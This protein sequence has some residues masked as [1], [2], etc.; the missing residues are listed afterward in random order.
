MGNDYDEAY[1]KGILEECEAKCLKS[2]PSIKPSHR[3][4]FFEACEKFHEAFEAAKK[5]ETDEEMNKVAKS[6]EKAMKKCVKS[7]NKIFEKLDLTEHPKIQT[8][9]LKGRIIVDAKPTGLADF[10]S[11]NKKNG[12][13]VDH[14]FRESSLMKRMLLNG[15]AKDGNYGAA[16]KIYTDILCTFPDEEDDF[17]EINRK[18]ALAVALELATPINEFDTKVPVDPV[19]RYVHF[20]EAFKN[21]ELDPAFPHF[22]IWELRHVVNCDAKDDQM[23]WGRDMLMNYAPYVSVITEQK[24]QYLYILETDVLMRNPSWT[25]SPRTYQQVLSGGGK[26]A[27]NAWFGRFICKSFGIPTWGCKQESKDGLTRWTPEG[28]EACR[29]MTWD[30]CEWEDVSGVDFKGE[31]DARAAVPEENYYNSLVLLE[32]LAE[33]MDARRGEVPEEEKHILHPLRLWRSL[34]IIQKALMLEP[35]STDLFVRDGESPVKT[36]KEKYI[37]VYELDAPDDKIKD[38]NDKITIPMGASVSQFGNVMVIACL[39]GGKQ[40]NFAGAGHID[41]DLPDDMEPRTYKLTAEVNTVHLKQG[42]TSVYADEGE[43]VPVKIPYT[44]GGWTMTEP[45]EIELEAGQTLTFNR[46]NGNLGLA[47]RKIFLS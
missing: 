47:I 2:L 10:C 41:F 39:K 40:I 43:R 7:S 32:C 35:G 22:S 3:Q 6:Q 14:L 25:G 16:M 20:R 42:T 23:K 9:M 33:V 27:P 8:S 36:R 11:Q 24:S 13:L 26:D 28:W 38:K 4:G 12:K 37:E 21:G 46:E 5:A 17:T 30:E 15:G 1:F 45:V 31:I 34:S 29:G 19:S 44:G 18:I